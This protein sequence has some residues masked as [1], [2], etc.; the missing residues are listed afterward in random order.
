M[1]YLYLE[2]NILY[3]LIKNMSKPQ[4]EKKTITKKPIVKKINSSEKIVI[5]NETDLSNHF[6]R[7]H[8]FLRD[9][10]C[11]PAGVVHVVAHIEQVFKD[12]DGY[13][14]G[15]KLN[16]G[17]TLEAD[18]YV[19]CTGFK[20]LLLEQAMGVPFESYSNHLPAL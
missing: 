6:H 14:S 15:L 13:I 20:S 18:L 3:I 11:L 17:D 5:N 10:L 19:D 1:I 9:K 8:N 2:T 7:I 16:N 12:E 4:K